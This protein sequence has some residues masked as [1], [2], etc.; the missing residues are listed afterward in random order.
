MGVPCGTKFLREFI[1][2]DWAFFSVL[3]K[4]ILRL[5]VMKQECSVIVRWRDF[6]PFKLCYFKMVSLVCHTLLFAGL[7]TRSIQLL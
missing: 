3:R 5:G 1:F 6:I 2:A 7:N 4:L